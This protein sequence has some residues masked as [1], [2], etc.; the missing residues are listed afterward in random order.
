MS[1]TVAIEMV[2]DIVCPWCWLG[3]RRLKAAL[4]LVPEVTTEVYFCLLYTS[5]AADE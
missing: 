1:E 2:S 3:M 5:D 4:E